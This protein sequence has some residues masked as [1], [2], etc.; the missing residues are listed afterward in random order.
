MLQSPPDSGL[1]ETGSHVPAFVQQRLQ[2]AKGKS[3]SHEEARAAYEAWCAMHDY[4]PLSVPKFA[5]E[6][7]ALGLEKWKSCGVIRYRNLNL[8]AL[9]K[10]EGVNA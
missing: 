9:P 2:R 5:A 10:N 1:P 7:K 3:V 8:V 4:Q 6:L